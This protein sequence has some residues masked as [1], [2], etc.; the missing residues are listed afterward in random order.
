MEAKYSM[1]AKKQ[2]GTSKTVFSSEP[3]TDQMLA[4]L[5]NLLK[6]LSENRLINNTIL[7]PQLWVFSWILQG[8][9]ALEDCL[10]I[11]CLASTNRRM[12]WS[13]AFSLYISGRIFS[14]SEA[15]IRHYTLNVNL[16]L[17][18]NFWPRYYIHMRP[19]RAA[20]CSFVE[21]GFLLDPCFLLP[22]PYFQGPWNR[23]TQ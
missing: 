1:E 4:G 7:M 5:L 16:L 15:T 8:R 9:R 19:Q 12:K 20:F 18:L 23:V 6:L 2:S 21:C 22:P 11:Y 10:Y 3:W 14:L 13:E 17:N